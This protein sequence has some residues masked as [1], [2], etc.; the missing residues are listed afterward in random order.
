M[1]HK[2]I[3]VLVAMVSC[4]CLTSLAI[5][6][7]WIGNTPK[8]QNNTY[9]FIEVV[10]YGADVSSARMEAKQLLAQNE[11]L[12]RAVLVSVN[13]GNRQK[14]DQVIE[15]GDMKEIIHNNIT[16][17]TEI[18][19]QQYR[20]QAYPVDEYVERGH[21]QVKLYSLYIVGISDNVVFD[22]TYLTTNYGAPPIA[23]SIIPGLGQWYKGSKMKGVCL[24]GATA[25]CAAGA[26]ICEN[27]RNSYVKKIKET[28]K[29][30]KEYEDKIS[31]WETGRNICL[32]AAAAVW[33]YNLIDAAAAKGARRVEV[34][35]AN[36]RSFTM[37]PVATSEYAG[38][39][40][41]YNF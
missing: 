14:I 25:L 13:T 29:F 7:K 30:A 37:T 32:G 8:E 10:S 27:Q 11:Q 19:G 17:D 41:T 24:F 35:P 9:R 22:R 28:P 23:M 15:D 1:K 3:I 2:R 38:L 26:L 33:I 21:G 31:T 36:R 18:S 5:K 39:A 40:L 4:V 6:P 20:L 12:R 16:I 34:S